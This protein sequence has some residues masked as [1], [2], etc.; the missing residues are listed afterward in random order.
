[1][2]TGQLSLRR[3]VDVFAT[4]PARLLGLYP[5]KGTIAPGSDAD[6][7]IWDPSVAKTIRLDDLH[8]DG[9]YSIWEG[10]AV[11]GWPITTIVRGQVVVDHGRLLGSPK[12]GE[13][14]PRRIDPAVL[15]G[16]AV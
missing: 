16:P 1:M 12:L 2:A 7:V 9:D 11:R 10:R 3:F 5:R 6:I 8:H 15:N 14:L 13:W 4:N